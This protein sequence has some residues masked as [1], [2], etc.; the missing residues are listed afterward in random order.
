[1]FQLKETAN[2]I[3]IDIIRYGRSAQL[4]GMPQNSLKRCAQ[5]PKL[6]LA[7]P[8]SHSRGPNAG[9]EEAFIGINIAHPVQQFLVQKCGFD[10]R[11]PVAKK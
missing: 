1:M 4:D 10:R 5:P 11:L 8:S 6:L 3:R 9:A 7:E 2:P